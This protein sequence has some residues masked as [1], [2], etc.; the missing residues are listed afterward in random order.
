VNVNHLAGYSVVEYDDADT[1]DLTLED[2]RPERWTRERLRRQ[3]QYLT[4]DVLASEQPL[5]NDERA[6]LWREK[7]DILREELWLYFGGGEP[8]PSLIRPQAE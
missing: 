3:A 6:A 7:R 4:T 1:E 2:C 8:L 5:T